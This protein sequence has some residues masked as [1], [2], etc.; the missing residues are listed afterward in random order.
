MLGKRRV[1]SL[2]NEFSTF[3]TLLIILFSA[4][5]FFLYS[6]QIEESFFIFL[7]RLLEAFIYTEVA[8]NIIVMLLSVIFWAT[9]YSFEIGYF[10]KSILRI[11]INVIL[12]LVIQVFEIA[13]NRGFSIN[14]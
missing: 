4:M 8:L 12:F 1:L 14:L 2:L 9:D 7:I 11:L 10:L 13:I 5:Y 3:L 6:F